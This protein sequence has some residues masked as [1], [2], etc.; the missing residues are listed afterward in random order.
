MVAILFSPTVELRDENSSNDCG[1][2]KCTLCNQRFI[3]S[4]KMKRHMI[5]HTGMYSI[6]NISFGSSIVTKEYKS[7]HNI[8]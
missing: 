8:Q 2:Y 4:R 1:L 3:N 6:L 5:T 7:L